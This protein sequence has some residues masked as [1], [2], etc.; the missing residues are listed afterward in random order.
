MTLEKLKGLESLNEIAFTDDERIQMTADFDFFA[1][2]TGTSKYC[3]AMQAMPMPDASMV[4]I[5]VTPAKTRRSP[6]R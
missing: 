4:R 6:S 2:T 3:A 5:F 1:K